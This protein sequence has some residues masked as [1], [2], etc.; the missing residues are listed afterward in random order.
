MPRVSSGLAAAALL[1]CGSVVLAQA[2]ADYSRPGPYI[3]LGFSY[4]KESFDVNDVEREYKRDMHAGIDAD[5]NPSNGI[6]ECRGVCE[7]GFLIDRTDSLGADFRAGYRISS[8]FAAEVNFQY[9]HNFDLKLGGSPRKDLTAIA[10]RAPGGDFADIRMYNFFVNGKFYPFGGPLQPY[11]LGGVGGVYA[12]VETDEVALARQFA[13]GTGPNAIQVGRVTS[14]SGKDSRPVFAGRFGGGLDYYLTRNLVI[15][16]DISYTLT[17]DYDV[18]GFRFN[19]PTES[20]PM[21]TVSEDISLDYIPITLALQ[22]R[23]N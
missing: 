1:L 2:E 20:D 22:Y 3:S 18:E 15:N 8:M 21:R 17:L 6:Q 19:R 23:L 4:G 16:F 9:Y 13:A 5:A 11:L 7:V 10:Q 12:E 14:R